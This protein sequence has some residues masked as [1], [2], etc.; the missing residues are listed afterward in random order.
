MQPVAILALKERNEKMCDQTTIQEANCLCGDISQMSAYTGYLQPSQ[1]NVACSESQA[2]PEVTPADS[3]GCTEEVKRRN[4]RAKLLVFLAALRDIL[5][6]NHWEGNHL[7]QNNDA[8]S[9]TVLHISNGGFI[10]PIL[11]NPAALRSEKRDK[12]CYY[13]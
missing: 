10:Q 7:F 2:L 3:G 4:L 6:V 5:F 1:M 11:W 13:N 8:L 12:H 9:H